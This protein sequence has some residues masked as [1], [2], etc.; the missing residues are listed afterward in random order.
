MVIEVNYVCYMPNTTHRISLL[1]IG[2]S[3]QIADNG[4]K[5]GN[6]PSKSSC[7]KTDLKILFIKVGKQSL[8]THFEIL[9]MGNKK[10]ALKALLFS[11]FASNELDRNLTTQQQNA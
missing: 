8:M 11:I 3:L 2:L 6:I 1:I 4:G 10:A 5:M 7:F 9:F